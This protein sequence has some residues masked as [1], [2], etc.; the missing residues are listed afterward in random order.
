M[1]KHCF[2]RQKCANNMGPETVAGQPVSPTKGLGTLVLQMCFVQFKNRWSDGLK[3]VQ[4]SHCRLGM[5]QEGTAQTLTR[6]L[7]NR[8][9]VGVGSSA[10]SFKA[11]KVEVS[12]PNTL[13]PPPTAHLSLQA[14]AQSHFL[15]GSSAL[16]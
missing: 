5:Q 3:E 16:L 13:P 2:E 6:K 8:K 10:C 11:F 7:R 14:S 9:Q 1:E 15:R 12:L 4:L